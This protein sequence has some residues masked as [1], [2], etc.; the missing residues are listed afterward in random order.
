MQ[1]QAATK[2]DD[3]VVT[4]T[5]APADYDGFG[6]R[7]DR[8]A[9]ARSSGK[10]IRRVRT[11]A[12]H[13]NWQRMRYGSGLHM[14]ADEAEFAKMREYGLLEPAQ[15]ATEDGD[16]P[17]EIEAPTYS[18]RDLAQMARQHARSAGG[19]LADWAVRI[20]ARGLSLVIDYR[21]NGRTEVAHV[22][23]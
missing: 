6:T 19:A 10:L 15:R 11:P 3:T 16:S 1:E 21:I 23:L 8:A 4:Y 12:P 7:T 22:A 9:V 17:A 18:R 14:A 5:T 2:T 20:H 13:V